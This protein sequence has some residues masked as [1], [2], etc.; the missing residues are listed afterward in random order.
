MKKVSY[1]LVIS[2]IFL[3]GILSFLG[4]FS[5]IESVSAEINNK[6]SVNYILTGGQGY[7]PYNYFDKLQQSTDVDNITYINRNGNETNLYRAIKDN[8]NL[9]PDNY[10]TGEAS[11]T[12]IGDM[13]KLVQT[14]H[15]YVYA[16]AGLLALK[17]K[18]NS[19]IIISISAN[20]Q[21][22][23]A[24][25]DLVH[26]GGVF[27]P[28][29]VE[30]DKIFLNTN[31]Q[32]VSFS[33]TNR[34]GS[35]FWDKAKFYIF[36]PMITF[37]LNIDEI[38]LD[39]TDGVV[40]EGQ[41]LELKAET[42]LSQ[43]EGNSQILEFYKN[44]HQIEW[45]IIKGS[46]L[47]YISGSYLKVTG[48]SGT[49]KVR[50]KCRANTNSD[51]YI[52]SDIIRLTIDSSVHNVNLISNFPEG[53]FLFGG[54]DYLVDE[55]ET[56]IF[57]QV[58]TGYSLLNILDEEG[59]EIPYTIINGDYRAEIDITQSR[60]IQIVLIKDIKINAIEIE[61]KYYD[62][63]DLATIK[64]IVIDGILPE[65][66]IIINSTLSARYSSFLPGSNIYVNITG[67]ITLS[68][69]LAY[70]YNFN[71]SIPDSYG[72]IFKRDIFV[73]AD[74]IEKEY[75]NADPILTYSYE[76]EFLPGESL[77]GELI[78]VEGEELGEY[79]ILQGSLDNPYYNVFF[80]SNIFKIVTRKINITDIKINDKVYD[81]TNIIDKSL[82]QLTFTG[83]FLNDKAELKF[84]ASFEDYN[85]G[86]ALPVNFNVWIEGE[87]SRYYEVI[88]LITDIK[89]NLILRPITINAVPTSKTYGE[90]DPI[91][92]F[93]YDEEEFM[94]GDE[95]S[96]EIIRSLGE[97]V[98]T[99][100]ISIGSLSA[101]NYDIHFVNADFIIQKR[102]L[103]IKA[104][105]K[106]KIYGEQ[107]PLLTYVIL[108]GNLVNGDV[109]G[110]TLKREI[111][112]SAGNYNIMIDTQSN[113]NYQADY[114]PAIF[115]ILKRDLFVDI[116]TQ[117]KIYDGNNY[118]TI[119]VQYQNKLL[120]DEISLNFIS[121]FEGAN[122]GANSVNYYYQ[123]LPIVEFN[124]SVFIG[125][126]SSYNFIFN[127]SYSSKIHKKEVSII[128][129]ND[130][131][132]KYGDIDKYNYIINGLGEGEVLNGE[133]ERIPGE[134]VG[135][136]TINQ[137]SLTNENN[138]NYIINFECN[139]IFIIIKRDVKIIVD[140]KEIFYGEDEGEIIY[141]LS[142]TTPLQ[143]GVN[144]NDILNGNPTREEGF[145]QG[146]YKY[147]IGSLMLK[148]DAKNNYNLIFEAGSLTI[149]RRIVDIT[150]N[151]CT[152][153]YGEDDPMII[154]QINSGNF[155]D[156]NDLSFSRE[157]GENVGTY[158]INVVNND[159]YEIIANHSE[160]T[161]I[162]AKLTIKA[163]DLLKIY[164]EIDP[165]LTFTITNGILMFND[166]IKDVFSGEL[167][168]EVGE[169][170]GAYIIS[171][172]N[173]ISNPNYSITFQTGLLTIQK[174]NLIIRANNT[175]KFL[176]EEIW[177]EITY[178]AEGLVKGDGFI[179]DLF[180]DAPNELGEYDIQI[181]SLSSLNYNITF[182]SAKYTITKRTLI[183]SIDYI[184]KEYDG[185][186]DIEI[187]YSISGDIEVGDED[188]LGITIFKEE[189]YTVGKYKI[190]ATSSND[191]YEL[192]VNENYF[193]ILPRKITIKADD[194]EITYGEEV[195]DKSLWT[196]TVQG[197][198]I[199]NE[200]NINLYRTQNY[201][202]GIFKIFATITNDKNY[203]VTFIP[204][205]LIIYK[206][207]INVYVNNYEKIY[208][209]SDPFLDYS[210]D[211]DALFNG[212]T[213]QGAIIREVGEDAGAYKLI[214]ALINDN[215]NFIMNEA[216]LTIKPREL[217]LVAAA[218]D[219]TYDDTDI[220]YLRMPTLSGIYNNDDVYLDYKTDK[221][222]RYEDKEVGNDKLVIVYGGTL[223]GAKAK[224]YTLIRPVG[225]TSSI[226]N[227]VVQDGEIS[228]LAPKSNTKLKKGTTLQ[229]TKFEVDENLLGETKKAINAFG[230]ELSYNNEEFDYGLVSVSVDLGREYLNIQ[231][232]ALGEDGELTLLKS[233]SKDNKVFF[234]S[235]NLGSYIIVVDN[236]TWLDYFI[237]VTIICFVA[238]MV[239]V[240]IQKVKKV[241]KE[242]K[243]L[244]IEE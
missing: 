22:Q 3:T 205:E 71:S 30:T 100:I 185:T 26:N 214:C 222:A 112:E 95:F 87:E 179:I 242:R 133:L 98:G 79:E 104:D 240:T 139:G 183:I 141:Y 175:N 81:R 201:C 157:E 36:E 85:V 174:K 101:A 108:E 230:L 19:K 42:F 206:K 37:G 228:V 188:L 119:S 173:L 73:T 46:S 9:F 90:S 4:V 186:D 180:V 169:Q 106:T 178:I 197:Q 241:K 125:D 23:S 209:Q 233:N 40:T 198:I 12:L 136:Y 158:K 80:T 27:N 54:G 152:K 31:T 231:V 220:A 109:L 117:E 89:G 191:K 84:E 94:S 243:A 50:A 86:E 208:G 195:P 72:T 235:A 6:E 163:N 103:K 111:G 75:G 48:D 146:V 120:T 58:K 68:G 11:V 237:F 39:M 131:Y 213:L 210:L 8:V 215:Y 138:P 184:S 144:L 59:N 25:S 199:G 43:M 2:L 229:S 223:V 74:Y 172:G 49:I 225:L 128:I 82:I 236:I 159:N 219:K 200:L 145:N 194:I 61:N 63:N 14:G 203:D 13:L 76:G 77:N 70:Y 226:T 116:Y 202:A 67:E 15:Y 134:N 176:D 164:G 160:L 239:I 129:E 221:I 45:E 168:R 88:T 218:L 21:S 110:L 161:I 153:T 18:E 97:D 118:G 44:Y 96:G 137:G 170:A 147:L 224:N 126:V 92:A 105:P 143:E 5:R 162:S 114:T 53:A 204:G 149:K 155:A 207:D 130:I 47:G 66:N 38:T 212:D 216:I 148:Q 62:R 217:V 171:Q 60:K 196:Y 192:I 93:T 78:R 24:T 234:E 121:L 154:Y 167:S 10:S 64:N 65:H 156:I 91:L 28:D 127:V 190:T 113:I 16:S 102:V 52:Y 34:E 20:G 140:N 122:A 115:E 33:F 238:L 227:S 69:D 151:N 182:I 232:Y 189:G 51:E 181:R 177:P 132:K 35:S 150:V 55:T 1:L 83:S 165:K 17:D 135:S 211:A 166:N 32:S 124:S 193:E 187:I 107:D 29:W 142:S 244:N 56:V 123:G 99:Y 7:Y 57:A 41:L